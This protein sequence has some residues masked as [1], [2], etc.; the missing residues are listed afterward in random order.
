MKK[1]ILPL[2]T[3]NNRVATTAVSAPLSRKLTTF[4]GSTASQT[5]ALPSTKSKKKEFVI[6]NTSSV[7]VAVGCVIAN[8]TITAGVTTGAATTNVATG[9]VA[10]FLSLGSVWHR[11][12]LSPIS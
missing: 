4:T 11:I 10:R 3:Y 12:S 8:G 2:L 1:V 6:M 7:T 5:L 9:Q